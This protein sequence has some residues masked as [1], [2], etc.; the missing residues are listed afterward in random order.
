[1]VLLISSPSNHKRV[2]P[3]FENYLL[4]A[5][6]QTPCVQAIFTPVNR[7]SFQSLAL[8]SYLLSMTMHLLR[9]HP[10]HVVF[11][12]LHYHLVNWG[13]LLIVSLLFR[14]LIKPVTIWQLSDALLLT[15][16]FRNKLFR[17]HPMTYS[18]SFWSSLNI[19]A[20]DGA[21]WSLPPIYVTLFWTLVKLFSPFSS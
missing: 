17:D 18:S 21:S 11:H 19:Y 1:M 15:F 12:S 3:S 5:F 20:L 4:Q 14:R 10:C 13:H 6:H 2:L 8:S 16:K 7:F 9:L